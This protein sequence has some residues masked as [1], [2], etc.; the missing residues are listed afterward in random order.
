M[1]LFI[2]HSIHPEEG[3]V[4]IRVDVSGFISFEELIKKD[5]EFQRKHGGL[6]DSTIMEKLRLSVSGHFCPQLRFTNC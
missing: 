3:C 4:E 2:W 1:A 6:A 5:V